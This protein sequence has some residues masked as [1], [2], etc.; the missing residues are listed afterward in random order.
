[1]GKI[2]T[3]GEIMLRLSTP[4]NEKF[5]Q[6][7]E[8]DVC[9]GGGEA[10]VAVSLAN[11]GH[12]AEFVTKV[13]ENP[14]GACAVAALRKMGVETKHIA[15]GG[16]R[17]GIYFLET[18]A[19][20]RASNVVYDRA[21]SSIS[22]AKPEDFDFDAIFDGADWF[23]FT[24]I[25]PAVSDAATEVCEAALRAAKAKGVKV[26]CDLNFRKKLWTSEKAQKVMTRLMQYV[27]ICI[28]NE[29]DAEK[30]L[31]FKPGETDVTGGKLELAGYK[32]IFEQ[33][34][35]KFNFEYVISSLRVSHSASDNGWSACIYSRD[36]KEFY[37]SREYRVS[38]IVDRVGGGDSFA[39]GTICGFM[40][41]KDFKSAL[42]FGVAASAL[43]HTIPG[44]FNMVSRSDVDALVGGDGSGRVQR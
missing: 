2:V 36:T 1:M 21:H 29:E 35:A 39:G 40:D 5:L 20:M 3:L 43:K 4:G 34:V 22:T 25:T 24:G 27:D 7:D 32:D 38:P 17:L 9:Y 44:D 15:K 31:G 6:A 28:G 19:A 33:M 26:S 8:F 23:H 42:E 11:Y 41:G 10:N 14:I 37:H 12:D 18:G 16:E 30:V 13:P